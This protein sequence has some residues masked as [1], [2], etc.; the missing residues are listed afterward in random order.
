[1]V[2]D[3]SGG[4]LKI[5]PLAVITKNSEISEQGVFV[6][7]V[8]TGEFDNPPLD[9]EVILQW[10]PKRRC[11]TRLFKPSVAKCTWLRQLSLSDI[12]EVKG[13]VPPAELDVILEKIGDF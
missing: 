2:S 5:R 6:G 7:V 11:R 12:V 4:N 10:H 3:P 8:I 9:D 1:M 13:H